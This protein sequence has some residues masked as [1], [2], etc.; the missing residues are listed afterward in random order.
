MA[1]YEQYLI[2]LIY[3]IEVNDLLYHYNIYTANQIFL[4][5]KIQPKFVNNT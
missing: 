4:K 1:I 2:G 3:D 5:A